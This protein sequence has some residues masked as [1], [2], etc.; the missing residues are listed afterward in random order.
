LAMALLAF[1]YAVFQERPTMAGPL[2]QESAAILDRLGAV[3]MRGMARRVV[4]AT[5][6]A[7]G[8][9]PEGLRAA[10][11]D[12]ALAL[13]K[14]QLTLAAALASTTFPAIARDA[15]AAC[16]RLWAV[17]RRVVGTD[18]RHDLERAGLSLPEDV[19]ALMRETA[20]KTLS[21][22][23]KDVLAALDRVIAAQETGTAMGRA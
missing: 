9:S 7:T 6:F 13:S 12:M 11:D 3:F 17:R 16:L 8:V 5:Q 18:R 15:P 10:R 1:S 21:D 14:T 23:V 19:D 4:I 22:A 2:A 20:D